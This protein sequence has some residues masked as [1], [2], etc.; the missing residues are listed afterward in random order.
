MDHGFLCFR[1]FKF[2]PCE[3]LE[4]YE[5]RTDITSGRGV[6]HKLFECSQHPPNDRKYVM[7]YLHHT[8]YRNIAKVLPKSILLLYN[9]VETLTNC[10]LVYF[11]SKKLK[12]KSKYRFMVFLYHSYESRGFCTWI[13]GIKKIILGN[14]SVVAHCYPVPK[15]PMNHVKYQK[16]RTLIQ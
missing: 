12:F 6:I 2:K 4:D 8:S 3:M 11:T 9:F 10:F 16:S 5:K 1:W 14:I 7:Y 15:S 13:V